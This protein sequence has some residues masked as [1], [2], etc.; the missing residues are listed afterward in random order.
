MQEQKYAYYINKTACEEC[1]RSSPCPEEEQNGKNKRC[2]YELFFKY[3]KKYM[4]MKK[5]EYT[6]RKNNSY[7]RLFKDFMFSKID[8]TGCDYAVDYEKSFF[9]HIEKEIHGERKFEEADK[10]LLLRKILF[11]DFRSTNMPSDF[12]E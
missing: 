12:I 7:I 9:L 5:I 10:I 2:E 8:F 1:I 6:E 4:G 3:V 11:S